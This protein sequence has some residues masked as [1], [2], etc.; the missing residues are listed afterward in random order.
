MNANL[1]E[2]VL[3]GLGRLMKC[4]THEVLCFRGSV[5]VVEDQTVFAFLEFHSTHAAVGFEICCW[6]STFCPVSSCLTTSIFECS[7]ASTYPAVMIFLVDAGWLW[8]FYWG[9]Q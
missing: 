7:C 6:L 4:F 9:A 3:M 5:G 8:V 2:P 1:S